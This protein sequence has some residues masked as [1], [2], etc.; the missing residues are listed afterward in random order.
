MTGPVLVVLDQ[1]GRRQDGRHAGVGAGQLGQPGISVLGREGGPE[2]GPDLVLAIVVQLM[3]HPFLAAEQTAEIGEEPRLDG[4]DGEPG[5]V[6]RPVG[7]VTGVAAGDHALAVTDG[8]SGGQVLVDG[9]RG[10][11]QHAVG[12]GHVEVGSGAVL[13]PA[14][15]RGHDG[16]RRLHATAR[17]VG[18]GR[19]GQ[20]RAAVGTRLGAGQV[21]ADGQ[22]VDVVAGPVGARATLAVAGGGAE[23]DP[24]VDRA[25]LV[26]ADAQAV[27]HAGPEAL[28]HHVRGAGQGQER[29]APVGVLEVERR[30][31][32]VARAAVGVERRTEGRRAAAGHRP[33]L[34][35]GGAVVGQ[36]AGAPRRRPHG[37]QVEH[38]DAGQRAARAAR[39]GGVRRGATVGVDTSLTSRSPG[40]RSSSGAR[41]CGG[42]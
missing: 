1:L 42:R 31:P 21:A 19:P 25:Q 2:G 27:G 13:S 11:P 29:A 12:D 9:E 7:V 41:A 38:R 28:D 35:H 30:P 4:S 36:Q 37:G 10:Q 18:N 24:R 26:E 5:P 23:D 8:G 17:R 20:G 34:D 16:H 33:D 6:G 15:E 40:I 14:D 39:G 32:Q 3:G 22:V